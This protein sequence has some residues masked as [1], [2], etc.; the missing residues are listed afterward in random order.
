MIYMVLDSLITN[1][2]LIAEL[3]VLDMTCQFWIGDAYFPS[4][5]IPS[6][7]D[8]PGLG[9]TLAA[10]DIPWRPRSWGPVKWRPRFDFFPEENHPLHGPFFKRSTDRWSD[11][12][13]A[14][15]TFDLPT[16][17]QKIGK[18]RLIIWSSLSKDELPKN[19]PRKWTA[20][21]PWPIWPMALGFARGSRDLWFFQ[22]IRRATWNGWGDHSSGHLNGHLSC[23]EI[24]EIPS[25]RHYRS[26]M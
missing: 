22:V 10:K 19:Y 13:G 18:T 20:E 4:F 21:S 5:F 25:C 2:D 7:L 6:L 26:F 16:E 11:Q 9:Q 3:V 24:E 17:P 23:F 8:V 12:M 1:S 14:A 15:Q